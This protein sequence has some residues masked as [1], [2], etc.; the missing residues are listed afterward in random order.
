MYGFGIIGCGMIAHIHAN[1]ISDIP[2]AKLVGVYDANNELGKQFA[3]KNNTYC[4]E[5]LEAILS[6][7]EIDI[8]TICTPSGLHAEFAIKALLSGKNVIVEKPMALNVED[9]NRIIEAEKKSGKVCAVVS[10]LRFSDVSSEVKNSIANG[11]L[12]KIVEIG[13]YMKYHRDEEYYDNSPW[14]GTYAMD[15]GGALMNQG[16]HG[17]DFMISFFG[18]PE[19]VF[20]LCRTKHHRI[21]VEDTVVAVFEYK[22]GPIGVIEATTSVA[23][24]Y[25]RQLEIC[26]TKG[27]ILIEENTIKSRNDVKCNFTSENNE[28]QGFNNPAAISVVGHKLEFEDVI[29]AIRNNRKPIVNTAEGKKSVELIQAIYKSSETGMKISLDEQN[30]S[31]DC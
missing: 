2:E 22:N 30:F 6:C 21:E 23:P 8:V 19:S 20:S 11:E 1:A 15:G 17:V 27:S 4:F 12:G 13:L 3:G 29:D 25:P 26:G 9:C 5:T 18:M 10:Q 7:D 31:F 28:I 16:I 24:G 14:R